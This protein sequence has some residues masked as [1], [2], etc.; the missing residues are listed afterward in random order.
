MNKLKSVPTANNLKTISPSGIS[1]PRRG[2][3]F[4]RM[5]VGVLFRGGFMEFFESLPLSVRGIFEKAF[6]GNSK[7]SAIKA[8]CLDCCCFNREEISKCNVKKCPLWSYRPY[9]KEEIEGE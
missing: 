3:T 8:K 5:L 9:Q 2:W 6:S 4:E 1:F 7:S